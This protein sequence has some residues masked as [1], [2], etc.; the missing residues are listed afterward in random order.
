MKL[1][2]AKNS[3]F[4][5]LLRSPWWISFAVAAVL[6][7][8]ALAV[9][10][11]GLHLYSISA[12]LPFLVIGTI[13]LYR[14]AGLPS[15]ARVSTSQEAM[16]AMSWR[17]FADTVEQGFRLRGYE[18]KR[19]ARG[20]ADF[21]VTR[22][23]QYALVSCKR[24]KAASHGV[25]PLRE[26]RAASEAREGREDGEGSGKAGESIYIALNPLSE[27]AQRFARENR[28]E[29]IQGVPLVQMLD[30]VLRRR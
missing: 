29:V 5:I 13:A 4:A 9:L 1:R 12:G 17:D 6:T 3:L 15:A 24:W 14:Q 16:R 25:E 2:M 18:V 27:S 8:I 26:L 7:L 21:E 20:A 19:L 10:P 11:D 23:T 22:G 28:I 30:P